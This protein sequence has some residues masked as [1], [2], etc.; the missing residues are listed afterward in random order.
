MCCDPLV[1]GIVR[2]VTRGGRSAS[3]S[4]TVS[5]LWRTSACDGARDILTAATGLQLPVIAG[6]IADAKHKT[7]TES[8]LS[9]RTPSPFQASQGSHVANGLRVLSVDGDHTEGNTRK[10]ARTGVSLP[11]L[12]IR[13]HKKMNSRV[14]GAV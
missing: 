3:N 11:S 12:Q 14:L 10:S 4:C 6:T 1:P 2:T 8:S 13:V 7:Q 5:M 9:A